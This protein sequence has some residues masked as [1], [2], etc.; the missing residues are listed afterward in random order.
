MSCLLPFD[1][2]TASSDQSLGRVAAPHAAQSTCR[3]LLATRIVSGLSGGSLEMESLTSRAVALRRLMRVKIA[4]DA[5]I[6][7]VCC[8]HHHHPPHHHHPSSTDLHSQPH[9]SVHPTCRP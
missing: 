7:Q 3:D 8:D 5:D 1:E 6:D 2:D 9:L 4:D